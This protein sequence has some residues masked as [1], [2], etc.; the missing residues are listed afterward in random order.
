MQ[1]KRKM[2]EHFTRFLK[3]DLVINIWSQI[4]DYIKTN[5]LTFFTQIIGFTIVALGWRCKSDFLL[6]GPR[7]MGGESVR[8]GSFASYFCE[9]LWI[10]NL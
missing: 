7:S 1:G 9:R 6:Y 3:M 10:R 4:A 8:L 2:Y 5:V